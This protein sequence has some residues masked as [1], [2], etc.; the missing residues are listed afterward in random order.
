[1]ALTA[2]QLSSKMASSSSDAE[3]SIYLRTASP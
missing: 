3:E 1:M 2:I